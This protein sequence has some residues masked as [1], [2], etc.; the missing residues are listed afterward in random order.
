MT[1]TLSIHTDI[2]L[3]ISETAAK[4]LK[5]KIRP[6]KNQT[7][8]TF[9]ANGTKIN[10][11]G[12]TEVH[13]FVEEITIYQTVRVASQLQ[14]QRLF[15]VD[16]FSVNAAVINYRLGI[17]S[18]H[19]D[20][21]QIPMHSLCDSACCVTLPRTIC[22][23]ALTEVT[24]TVNSPPKF[25]NKSAM[26]EVWPRINPL[27]VAVAKASVSCRSNKT[28]RRLWNY[29]SHVVTLKKVS[30]WQNRDFRHRSFHR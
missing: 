8:P 2:E 1:Q 16:F 25:N 28:V 7:A 15:G 24:L 20:L 17:L 23:P 21:T 10:I 6:L 27:K 11:L 18:L 4:A 19:D 26:L 12:A 14:P 29:N 3:L 5:L 13:I 9:S 30:N 22:I